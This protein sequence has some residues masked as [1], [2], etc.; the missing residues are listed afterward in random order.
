MIT[1]PVSI[2]STPAASKPAGLIRAG[3]GT[4]SHTCLTLR[5]TYE[6]ACVCT[7]KHLHTHTC[8]LMHAHSHIC[9][10]SNE[11]SAYSGPGPGR[12][13]PSCVYIACTMFI[14]PARALCAVHMYS[15]PSPTPRANDE[16][17]NKDRDSRH[18]GALWDKGFSQGPSPSC[19]NLSLLSPLGFPG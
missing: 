16:S 18:N 5:D 8:T 9:T 1:G 12:P 7:S 14:L 4:C 3:P 2:A 13:Q 17:D 6:R 15:I 19:Q 11:H 10:H